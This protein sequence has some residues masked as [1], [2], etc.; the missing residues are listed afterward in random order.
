[1]ILAAAQTL[2]HKGDFL[3]NLETHLRLSLAAAHAGAAVVVFPELSLTGYEPELAAALALTPDDPALIPLSAMAM[4]QQIILIAGAPVRLPGG[5][6]I[7]AFVFLPDGET[8]LYTKH[9]LHSGEETFFSATTLLNP[10]FEV[11]GQRAALAICADITHPNHA[12]QA[13]Q[14]GAEL[15]LAGVFITPSGYETDCQLLQTYAQTHQMTVVMANFGGPSGN[16]ESAG[17]SMI[18]N[19]QGEVIA[20]WEGLGEGVLVG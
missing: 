11:K 19:P 17:G 4:Q 6:H 20:R 18:W 9:H 13:R 8:L 7:G 15:Y 16:F 10:T 14:G 5:I 3:A 12:A 2:P 1:M